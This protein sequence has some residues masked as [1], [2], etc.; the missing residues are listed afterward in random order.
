L[1]KKKVVKSKKT[2]SNEI[3][4]VVPK[5]AITKKPI[6]KV[7]SKKIIKKPVPKK[8]T[9]K[10]PIK[11]P[12]SK[13]ITTKKP[14]PKATAIKKPIKKTNFKTIKT[15]SKVVANKSNMIV[16]ED[17][18]KSID[19]SEEFLFDNELKFGDKNNPELPELDFDQN[20]DSKIPF[21]FPNMSEIENLDKLKSESFFSK[22]TDNE[23]EDA[24]KPFDFPKDPSENYLP[25]N[26][27][28]IWDKFFGKKKDANLNMDEF[29]NDKE[30]E[31]KESDFN[32]PEAPDFFD[33][34]E[35][36]ELT[37][38]K[39]NDN[40]EIDSFQDID[41]E[42]FNV[43]D[44]DTSNK[45]EVSSEIELDE[46]FNPPVEKQ[47]SDDFFNEEKI[48]NSRDVLIREKHNFENIKRK[49]DNEVRERLNYIKVKEEELNIKEQ[50]IIQREMNVDER[51][52]EVVL[53]EKEMLQV[54]V[55]REEVENQQISIHYQKQ[56][57]EELKSELALKDADLR[58]KEIELERREDELKL[59]EE[60]QKSD[61]LI[62]KENQYLHKQVDEED[63]AIKYLQEEIEKQRLDF[64]NQLKEF[65]LTKVEDEDRFKEIYTLITKCYIELS[66]KDLPAIK[67]TYSEIKNK[68]NT[69]KKYDNQNVV[70]KDVLKLFNDIKLKLN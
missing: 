31:E 12:V 8:I 67:N 38:I 65:H 4:K 37:K 11:K 33:E 16:N 59:A 47:D 7:V 22:K 36:A 3:R 2:K 42:I 17:L 52:K 57:I 49:N 24:P 46:L 66:H 39:Q 70:F 10:K 9:T 44:F 20:D 43:P 14:V 56:K 18:I 41:E 45:K 29:S 13:K 40:T 50:E 28:S 27:K 54:K 1:A 55:L 61:I 64:E 23:I 6:K 58:E 60:I 53:R 35:S 32:I 21:D 15:G 69:L 30:L 19:S 5:K 25:K 34:E 26:K 68:Y 63:E 48:S 51:E 62:Q